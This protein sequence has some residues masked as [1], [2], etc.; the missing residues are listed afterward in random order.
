MVGPE[1]AVMARFGV[2]RLPYAQR[3]ARVR[4]LVDLTGLRAVVTGG[5]GPNLGQA[6]VHRLAGAGAH[7]V[8]ADIDGDAAEAVA[9]DAAGRWSATTWAVAGSTTDWGGAHALIAEARQRLGGIDLL[10]NNVGG[11]AGPFATMAREQIERVVATTFLSTLYCSRAVLDEMLAAGSGCIVN[12][13]SEG[14][15]MASPSISLYNSCKA[16]VNGFTRNLAA[17]VGPRGVRVVGVAPGMML[18]DG[19]VASLRNPAGAEARIAAMEHTL[20]RIS[21]GRGCL[22]EEVANMVVFLA[23]E[24]GAHVHGTTVSVG[25]GMSS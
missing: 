24:A 9:R 1:S 10:V 23:S 13:S 17:E 18:G 20:E 8:V 16:G 7:V 22:P 2:D 14:A 19:L 15:E 6:I 21:V 11:G 3:T 4:D 25:G 12:I 5:G